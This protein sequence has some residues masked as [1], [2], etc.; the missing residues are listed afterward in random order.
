MAV[1]PPRIGALRAGL[2]TYGLETAVGTERYLAA[3]AAITAAA[4]VHETAVL[5]RISRAAEVVAASCWPNPAAGTAATPL[6]SHG[7]ST[8]TSS[9]FPRWPISA[10]TGP[11]QGTSS[12]RAA[13]T[14]LATS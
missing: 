13:A 12:A 9:R 14:T 1:T 6:P 2:E 7:S 3:A 11:P 5:H 4:R 8:G 10:G